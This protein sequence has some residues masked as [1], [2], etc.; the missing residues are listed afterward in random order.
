MKILILNPPAENTIPEYPRGDGRK[1][2]ETEDFGAFPPLGA[3]YVL[4]YLEKNSSGHDYYFKDCVGERLSHEGLKQY[5]ASIKP[6]IIGITSFTIALIDVCLAARNARAVAPG[7][8]ICMGGHHPI[9]FP[10]Q[11][12]KLKEFDS[13]VV[14]EGEQAFTELVAALQNGMDIT[15]IKGVYTSGSIERF[16]GQKCA[17]KRFGSFA[18]VPPAYVENLDLIPEPNRKYIQHIKYHSVVGVTDRLATI[19]STR[20]CPYLCTFCDVP[21]KQYRRRSIEKV[22]DEIETCLESG[23]REF[24][25]YD[26]LFNISSQKVIGFCDELEKRRLKITWD[27]RG[28]VNTVTRE[29]LERAKRAGCR[30]ISFGVE[31]GTDEGLIEL[32][33]GTTVE[34]VVEVFGWCRE[35]GIKTIA[36]FMIGLPFEKSREDALKS[37]DF[38]VRLDPDYAQVLILMLLPNT[39]IFEQAEKKGIVKRQKWEEFSLN[40]SLDFRIDYWEEW[41]SHKELIKLQSEAY[42]RYYL[43]IRYVLRSICTTKTTHEFKMKAKAF[44]KLATRGQSD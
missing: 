18:C 43:R 40:P 37:I 16:R 14:G 12:A 3:L 42:R 17:D 13:I 1:Y 7:V 9:A 35:L 25:F 2:V 39:E 23:Y 33:K 44:M 15:A 19:I 38:L 32:K 20:G 4:S 36:D 41:L 34:K 11:A 10:F 29:S 22:V 31:T 30:M 6:D 26:D 8:H 27:F 24:H 21:Y 5:I 28:R